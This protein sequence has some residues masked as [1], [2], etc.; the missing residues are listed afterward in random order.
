MTKKNPMEL[1]LE[2]IELCALIKKL[3]SF[4]E[5]P[6][7]AFDIVDALCPLMFNESGKSVVKLFLEGTNK[8]EE[9]GGN[10]EELTMIATEMQ[11]KLKE[12]EEK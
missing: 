5:N 3:P 7:S 10:Q 1:V 12:L 9:A 6:C 11:E 8:L 4:S 2:L